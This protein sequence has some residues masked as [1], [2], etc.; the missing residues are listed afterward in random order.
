MLE[1]FWFIFVPLM[2]GFNVVFLVRI[3]LTMNRIDSIAQDT[4]L[5]RMK[6]VG[7]SESDDPKVS[8]SAEQTTVPP[9]DRGEIIKSYLDETGRRWIIRRPAGARA[10]TYV[11]QWGNQTPS[12]TMKGFYAT[13][14]E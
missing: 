5:L 2:F 8:V 11:D 3:W 7:V 13:L 14:T 10:N 9:S 6:L 4:S 1:I 12:E